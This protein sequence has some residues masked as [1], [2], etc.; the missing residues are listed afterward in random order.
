MWKRTNDDS[1]YR[2]LT[3]INRD[4]THLQKRSTMRRF[5][6]YQSDKEKV[7]YYEK[8]METVLNNIALAAHITAM[9]NTSTDTAQAPQTLP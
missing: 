5:M 1:I 8:E 9:T 4:I 7:N 3:E 6:Q 2:L